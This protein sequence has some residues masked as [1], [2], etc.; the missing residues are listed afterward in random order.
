ML[1]R[2]L[3]VAALLLALGSALSLPS[4]AQTVP[5]RGLVVNINHEQRSV[6][7]ETATGAATLSIAPDAVIVDHAARPFAF[8]DLARGDAIAY[9]GRPERVT[10]LSVARHY[11]AVPSD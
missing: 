6:V 3:R 11:W 10:H 5:L 7:V 9:R 8:P 1:M 4:A 2:S